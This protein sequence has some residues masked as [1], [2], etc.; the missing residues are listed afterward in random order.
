[1]PRHP[2]D[3]ICLICVPNIRKLGRPPAKAPAGFPARLRDARHAS[4]LGPDQAAEACG[5]HVDTWRAWERGDNEP[6][7]LDGVKVASLLGVRNQ[8]LAYGS[9]PRK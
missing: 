5:V 9:G 3:C 7:Y 6:S 8:W 1:M 2:K 4:E